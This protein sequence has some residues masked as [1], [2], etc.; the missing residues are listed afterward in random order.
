MYHFDY[1]A[2]VIALLVTATFIVRRSRH[3]SP[4]AFPPGPLSFPVVGNILK[5]P[6]QAAWIPFSKYHAMYG[7]LVFFHGLGNYV[8]VLNSMRVIADLLEKRATVYSDRPTFTVVGELMGLGQSMPLLPYGDE[9]RAQRKLAHHA[10]SPSAVKRYHAVQEDLAALLGQQLLN[11]PEDFFMKYLPGWFHFHREANAGK[12][13]IERM[14][15]R[16]FEHVKAQMRTGSA[17]PSLSRQLLSKELTDIHNLE[18]HIKWATGSL[19]GVLTCIMAMALHP[20]YQKRA[21]EEIDRVVGE[22]RLP[23][24]SD[25]IQLPYVNAVIKETMRWHPALPLSIARCTTKDDVYEGY[26]IP[27]GTIVV[28]NV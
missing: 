24:I 5:V 15:N 23:T 13:M 14:V 20:E 26:F 9:W 21:Q 19:Y 12:A 3:S 18:H 27:K 6:P 10:L 22:D 2:A 11:T 17:V 28:P 16:P 1:L 7:E 4:H 25:R 8:L